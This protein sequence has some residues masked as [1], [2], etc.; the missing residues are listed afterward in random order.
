MVTIPTG[1]VTFLFTDIEGSTQLLNRLGD[2]YPDLL[3][4]HRIILRA[5][6]AKHGGYEVGTEGD[7]F[8]VAFS[9]AADGIAAAM[10]A[11]EEL[12][13]HVWPE[14]G[15]LTVRM[16]LHTGEPTCR[17]EDYTGL[18]VHRAARI[19]SAAHG[20]QVLLSE[21][22]KILAGDRIPA[23]ITFRDLGEHRLKD[24]E[25]PEHIFQ[26]VLPGLRSDFPPIRSLN[27]CPNNLPAQITP[28]IGRAEQLAEVCELLRRSDVRLAT[29]TGPAGVGKTLLAL[30]AATTL[31]ADFVDGAFIV[32]L[33]SV[34]DPEL[35]PAEIASVLGVEEAGKQSILSRLITHLR[36]KRLL[37]LLDNLEQVTGAARTFATILEACPLVKILGTSR[38]PLYLRSEH[39][40]PVPPLDVPRPNS[41][42]K[43]DELSGSSAVRLFI[44]RAE[45]VRGD[46]AIDD[47]NITAVAQICSLLDG[48][49]LA[50]E[51]AAAR[52]KLLSPEALLS[53][54]VSSDGHVSL[55]LLTGGAH[56]LPT[57]QQTVRDAI[58]WSYN[59]LNEDC[60]KIF[61]RL[62]VFAGGSTISTAEAVC[63]EYRDYDVEVVDAIGFL[64]DSNLLRHC[65][66]A[67][68][69]PRISMLQTIREFGL[70]QLHKSGADP[71]AYRAYAQYFAGFAENAEANRSGPE[72]TIWAKRVET[73]HDNFRAALAWSFDNAP[74]LAIQIVAAVGE[75]W[76]RQA[77]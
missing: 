19:S 50:T 56:D 32:D 25:K 70:D 47:E 44:E 53:R 75:F 8:F 77:H 51:L 7:A 2:R 39:L 45:A 52:M 23:D 63:N 30:Q 10:C 33:A 20:G 21:A 27:S 55:H 74:E 35:V 26:L 38:S 17:G 59:L 11:Q 16:G 69:E 61:C 28:L 24:L 22:T 57:R 66:A 18:D 13:R 31:L 49:P 71:K 60:K 36:E 5:A 42:P 58:A 6:L 68:G 41:G 3:A 12:A 67:A 4:E 34:L 40:F 14:N 9:R 1:T 64:I 15:L 46:F 37:L 29:L 72:Y 43:T 54:L 48:V 73:E 76:F 62:A 65:F